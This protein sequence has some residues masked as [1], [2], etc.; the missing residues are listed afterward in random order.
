MA[1]VP[2]F[3][4]LLRDIRDHK[5]PSIVTMHDQV[6]VWTEEN[7][8]INTE[9]ILLRNQVLVIKDETQTIHDATVVYIVTA[10]ADIEAIREQTRVIYQ[11]TLAV[12][13]TV[14]ILRD[15][16]IVLRNETQ[17]IHDMVKVM[18]EGLGFTIDVNGHL[19]VTIPA[20]SNLQSIY[21][22]TDGH[23]IVDII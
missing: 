20:G 19:I 6:F 7:R 12:H 1:Q 21:I 2:E 18:T 16:V 13:G 8:S 14:V 22:D 3:I 17:D 10:K 23:L 11:D 15:E 4:S 9:V 5:Y